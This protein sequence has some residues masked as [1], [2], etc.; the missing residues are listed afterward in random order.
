VR[1]VKAANWKAVPTGIEHGT[2]TVVIQSHQFE[3][4]TLREDREA[5]LARRRTRSRRV[6]PEHAVRVH[7]RAHL[8]VVRRLS[9]IHI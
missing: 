6:R 3:V 1:R 7:E 4:T 5:V 9:L 2:V 8:L